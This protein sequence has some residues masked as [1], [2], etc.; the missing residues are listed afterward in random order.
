MIETK[1]PNLFSF[2]ST[3]RGNCN[4][5]DSSP[6]LTDHLLMAIENERMGDLTHGQ[7]TGD[8]SMLLSNLLDPKLSD[9]ATKDDISI[10]SRKIVE[11]EQEKVS[12][13]QILE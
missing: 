6:E 12:M 3:N 13:K 2:A 9:L 8:M 5:L 1:I 4:K 10:V 11:L 7:L